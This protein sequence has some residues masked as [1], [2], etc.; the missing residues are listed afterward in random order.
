MFL[1]KLK[2]GANKI[3]KL[4][5]YIEKKQQGTSLKL[6]FSVMVPKLNYLG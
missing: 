4:H 3:Y 6:N 2:L 5:R 1:I